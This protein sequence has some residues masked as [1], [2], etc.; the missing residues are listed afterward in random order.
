M[1]LTKEHHKQAKAAQG[2]TPSPNPQELGLSK[3]PTTQTRG[4]HK[5]MKA[6]RTPP[7]YTITEYD[8]KMTT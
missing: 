4:A 7:D 6:Q 1:K 3:R 8:A 5:N 2:T